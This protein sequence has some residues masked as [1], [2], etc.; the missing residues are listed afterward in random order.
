[1]FVRKKT[2]PVSKK[3]ETGVTPRGTTLITGI[4]GHSST[5]FLDNGSTGTAYLSSAGSSRVA[6]LSRFRGT[7]QL[8]VPS[9]SVD[10]G[11]L[12]IFAFIF[13]I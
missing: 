8:S 7:S 4:S 12:P 6:H 3:A 5:S 13:N 9:L 11:F 2:T 1:M 10:A